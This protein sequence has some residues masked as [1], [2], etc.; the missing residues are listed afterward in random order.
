MSEDSLYKNLYNLFQAIDLCLERKLQLPTLMLIYSGIDICGWLAEESDNVSIEKSFTKW[1]DGYM[2]PSTK[3]PCSSIDLYAAR[4]GILHTLTPDSN[5]YKSGRAQRIAY[6]WG[7]A[8][9]DDL[10]RTI[11]SLQYPNLIA[12]HISSLYE[13]FRTGVGNFMDA[14]DNNPALMKTFLDKSS[15]T[16]T[17]TE[18]E[19]IQQYLTSHQENSSDE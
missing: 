12:I 18:K 10:R 6:A 8:N 13:A 15:K 19:L 3:L 11:D 5:L 16:F 7:S 2:L 14:M 1:V 9:V 17:H 4:C